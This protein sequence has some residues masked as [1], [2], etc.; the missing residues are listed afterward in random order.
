MKPRQTRFHSLLADAMAGFLAYK[1]AL[2][3]VYRNEEAALRLLDDYLA[4]Q[5][6]HGVLQITPETIAAFLLSRPRCRP[7]SYNHLLGVVRRFFA[8]LVVQGI[9][10]ASPVQAHPRPTTSRRLPFLFDPPLARRLLTVA[11]A[12]PDNPRAPL[13]GPT[14]QMIFALL[15]GLGLRVGEV[16]KLRWQDVDLDNRLLVIRHAKFGKTRLVPFGPKIGASLAAYRQRCQEA[17]RDLASPAPVFS[18][19]PGRAICTGAISQTFHQLLPALELTIPPGVRPPR[20]H[21]LRHSF[22]VG[23]LRHWYETGLDP[24]QRLLHLSTFLGHATPSSTAVYLTITRELLEHASGRF[25]SSAA[26]VAMEA[27][28]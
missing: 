19:S 8:W 1:R 11:A 24:A 27:T 9:V 5:R 6:V 3:R 2:K 15:Y 28:P 26:S 13:R 20:A 18:F 10:P 16:A 22:A 4:Q 14:Y 21:D 25:A 17:R 23:T 7:R 12:L